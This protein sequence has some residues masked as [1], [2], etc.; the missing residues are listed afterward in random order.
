MDD[1][2]SCGRN[3]TEEGG[4]DV[5]NAFADEFGIRIVTATNHTV[6]DAHPLQDFA[7]FAEISEVL[8]WRLAVHLSRF[9]D[10]RGLVLFFVCG[11][12]CGFGACGEVG[13]VH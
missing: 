5:G 13:G 4:E 10:V 6:R 1:D 2:G 11:E 9:V 12:A 7:V 8:S 3:T